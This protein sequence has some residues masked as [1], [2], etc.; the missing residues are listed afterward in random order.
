LRSFNS[1]SISGGSTKDTFIFTYKSCQNALVIRSHECPH[2]NAQLSKTSTKHHQRCFAT[3]QE[4]TRSINAMEELVNFPMA[5]QQL[6]GFPPPLFPPPIEGVDSSI[7]VNTPERLAQEHRVRT[8][9]SSH[10]SARMTGH[11]IKPYPKP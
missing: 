9:V 7:C 10:T 8:Q 1:T 11:K 2:W 6:S 3:I 4:K 5:P